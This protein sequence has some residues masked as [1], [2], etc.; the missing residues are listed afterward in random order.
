M[1]RLVSALLVLFCALSVRAEDTVVFEGYP[2]SRVSSNEEM[3]EREE[4]NEAQSKEYRVLIVKRGD[5]YFWASRENKELFYF[6]SGAIHW[7]IAPTSGY[8]K[9]VDP[10][11]LNP[12]SDESVLLY[13]EHMGL[14][15]NLISYWG[16]G[17]SGL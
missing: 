3:T 15:T 17:E 13:V 12:D 5:K 6:T 7:F 14:V 8:I 1:M 16:A 4:L 2:F 10:K 11:L 9:I